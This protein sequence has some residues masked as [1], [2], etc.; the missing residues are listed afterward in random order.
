[1]GKFKIKN[2]FITIRNDRGLKVY[3]TDLYWKYIKKSRV[4][5]FCIFLLAKIK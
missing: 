2:D 5:K 3:V 4:I 1:M